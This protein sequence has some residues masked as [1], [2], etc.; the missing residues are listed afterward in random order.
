[1]TAAQSAAYVFC[2]GGSGGHLF[3]GLAV[4]EQLRLEVPDVRCVFVGAGRSIESTVLTGSACEFRRLE[5]LPA[6]QLV[7]HPFRFARTH[8]AAVRAA[9][10]ILDEVRPAAV[11][12]LGGFASVPVAAA[13]I[14][15]GTPLVLLEQN[16]VPG[17]ATSWLARRADVVCTSFPDTRVRTRRAR[18]C[19]TGNPVR[20]TMTRAVFRPESATLLVL[21]GSQ[22][23]TRVNRL[24]LDAL[25]PGDVLP[26]GWRVVH[27]TGSADVASVRTAYA[28]AGIDAVV[29]DFIDDLP[30]T[31]RDA[32]LVISR[33]GGT[34]LAELACLGLPAILV[35]YPR[36]VRDHQLRN[37][38]YFSD[39]GA[40]LLLQHGD[41]Q[42]SQLREMLGRLLPDASRRAGMAD[43][44]RRLGRP[45]ASQTVA[46]LL[47]ET[48][49]QTTV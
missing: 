25:I 35:P 9:E 13:A 11:V 22:G 16:R 21:G 3:P 47:R 28:A 8:R 45:D 26:P 39:S 31:V 30:R 14:R 34:T 24:V 18:V 29:Q 27:Q 41:S 49:Q 15:H 40:A 37:A 17:R 1:M 42:T 38:C 36:S 7:R 48:V 43:I 32:G 23:A 46:G 44:M 6:S 2:G 5:V 12:G 19:C 20:A 4:V 33:A 10:S